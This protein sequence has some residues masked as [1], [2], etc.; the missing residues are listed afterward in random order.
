MESITILLK[1][2]GDSGR[3]YIVCY[4]IETGKKMWKKG[5]N[6]PSGWE[7]EG[8]QVYNYKGKN[9]FFIGFI[10]RFGRNIGIYYIQ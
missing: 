8:I 7:P 4:N 9:R 1:D 3:M 10:R 2:N 5:Y 6:I